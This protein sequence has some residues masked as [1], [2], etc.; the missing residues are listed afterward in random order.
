M[1]ALTRAADRGVKLRIY[2][3]GTQLAEREP[4]KVFNAETPTGPTRRHSRTAQPGALASLWRRS[5]GRW[6]YREGGRPTKTG[7]QKPQLSLF[8]E[9]GIDKNLAK[10]A[11][12]FAALPEA[13]FEALVVRHAEAAVA[14]FKRLSVTEP[15]ETHG[16]ERH[17]AIENLLAN[18][19]DFRHATSTHLYTGKST[20]VCGMLGGC[21]RDTHQTRPRRGSVPN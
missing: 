17:R 5:E 19:R 11:R 4:A 20:S 15:D 21:L 10:Q 6:G 18:I 2:L 1:Q 16:D 12:K 14:T 7:Y 8:T 9:V 13:K 3:D